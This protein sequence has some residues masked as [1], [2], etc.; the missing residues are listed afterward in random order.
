VPFKK[1]FE[2][3]LYPVFRNKIEVE[4]SALKEN[5]SAILGAAALTF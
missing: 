4:L 1:Y 3:N 2:E 5:D